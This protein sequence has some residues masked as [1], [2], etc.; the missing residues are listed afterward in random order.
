MANFFAHY[1]PVI[2]FYVVFITVIYQRTSANFKKVFSGLSPGG[3]M[4]F[5]AMQVYGGIVTLMVIY[6]LIFDPAVQ[7]KAPNLPSIM[8]F[9]L[10]FIIVSVFNIPLV[11]I[12]VFGSEHKLRGTYRYKYDIVPPKSIMVE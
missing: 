3:G 8:F 1:L 7:Y 5:L 11:V 4:Y 9:I 10:G 6:L 12:L 2:V